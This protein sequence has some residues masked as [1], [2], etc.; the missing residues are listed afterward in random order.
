MDEATRRAIIE[1]SRRNAA[2][3]FAPREAE[4]PPP[5]AE[6]SPPRRG[7]PVRSSH[8]MDRYRAEAEAKIAARERAAQELKRE[9]EQRHAEAASDYQS[10][11][12]LIDI[13][14]A[15][16]GALIEH[17]GDA[18][19][20]AAES[21]ADEIQALKSRI[22]GLEIEL[23]KAATQAADARTALSGLRSEI[24]QLRRATQVELKGSLVDFKCE[25]LSRLDALGALLHSA[26]ARRT[27]E[28]IDR[29]LDGLKSVN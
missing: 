4:A 17:L 27:E 16:N 12:A 7:L 13:K 11:V 18:T 1:E 21:F 10:L 20:Q 5:D 3:R 22:K 25:M 6:P 23:S 28:V 24:D 19:C 26:A 14:A 15:E 8:E 2:D 29:R 9:S